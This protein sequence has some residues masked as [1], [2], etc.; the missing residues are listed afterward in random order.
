MTPIFS[1]L[2]SL[3][4]IPTLQHLGLDSPAARNLVLGTAAQESGGAYLAQWPSG[5]ARSFWQ[6]EP[7][8]A[9]DLED[10]FVPSH[11][12][13]GD[14]LRQLSS[15][16]WPIDIELAVNLPY[17]CATCRLLYYRIPA[18]LPAATDLAGLGAYWKRY[19]N[20]PLGAGTAEEWVASFA[21]CIGA[22]PDV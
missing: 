19:Y 15:G 9:V 7:A 12:V 21:R 4:I 2:R 14:K 13:L 1:Q 10:N 18:A 8:T 16:L 22:P 20:T 3:V 6:I 17:A 5:P 11:K